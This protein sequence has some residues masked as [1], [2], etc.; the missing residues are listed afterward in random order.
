M[1]S[2][3]SWATIGSSIWPSSATA[4][5]SFG[6]TLLFLSMGWC[7]IQTM[8]APGCPCCIHSPWTDRL[9]GSS[10]KVTHQEC[11]RNSTGV[12]QGL[13]LSF[14]IETKPA[15]LSTFLFVIRLVNHCLAGQTRVRDQTR[16]QCV[17]L[18]HQ[19]CCKL[20]WETLGLAHLPSLRVCHLQWKALDLVSQ[21]I[22]STG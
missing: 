6:F 9:E 7:W 16:F 13:L 19:S 5:S 12:Q 1:G 22:S 15:F 4:V 10:G 3:L 20:L 8:P 18:C 14:A 21:V 11:W 2:G 17:L